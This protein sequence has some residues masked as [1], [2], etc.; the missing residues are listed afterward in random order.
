M[1]GKIAILIPCFNEAS[2]IATVV[3]DFAKALP[4]ATIY[5]YDN[6]STDGTGDAARKAGAVVRRETQQGK[7]HVVRRMFADIEADIYLMTDGDQTYDP[8]SARA[9]VDRLVAD[10]LDMVVGTRIADGRSVAYRPGHRTGNRLLTG[11]VARLF[12][13]RFTD[14]FSGYRAF[15]RRFV[16]S[17]PALSNGFE[18]ETELTVHAL[19]LALPSGEISTPYR[20]RPEGSSSK[21]STLGDGILIVLTIFQ[22]LRDVRPLSFFSGV[23]AILAVLALALSYPLAVTYL[24]TGLVPRF[25]TA[26]LATGI[27]LIAFVSATCGV[28][29]DSVARGRLE[30]KRLAY[31]ALPGPVRTD[32]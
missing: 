12:G 28:I 14:I 25:P 1:P 13:D 26:I 30:T 21:L 20:A 4:E 24:E 15:S 17:F 10:R 31:L 23:A 3:R 32:R 18:I 2:T 8:A 6:N 27:M 16:K 5:V 29:L 7:G 11:F 22:L 19:E 9:L